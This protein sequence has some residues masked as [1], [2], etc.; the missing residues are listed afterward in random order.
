MEPLKFN[1]MFHQ[2]VVYYL[3]EKW[4]RRLNDHEKHLVAEVHDYV[5]TSMEVEE[6]KIVDESIKLRS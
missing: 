5:R 1:P 2:V 6:I 4:Q 3:E